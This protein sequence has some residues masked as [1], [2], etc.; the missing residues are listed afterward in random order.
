MHS[1]KNDKLEISIKNM[2]AELCKIASV[3]YQ[4]HFM[5]DANPDVW[6]GYAPNLFPIVGALKNNSYLFEG[7]TYTLPKHGFI[8]NND[9]MELHEKTNDTLTFKLIY[10]EK[11]LKMYP[12]K[13][14][15]YISFKLIDNAIQIHHT[16]KNLDINPLYFSL[17]GHPAFKCPVFKN[18]NYEDYYLE[19]EHA[20]NS[21]THLIDMSNGLISLDTKPIFNNTN[22]L[23]LKH[24]L[25]NK[26]A[27][28]FK[29][30]KSKK[31]ALKSH[32]KGRILSV[33]FQDFPYLGI[34]AKPSGD[35]VCIEPWLGIADHVDTNQDF[36]NKD[37]IIKLNPET[38][39][40]ASYLVEIDNSHLV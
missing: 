33:E 19:F 25:F 37:G 31:V 7:N 10:S 9:D 38:E 5:W 32:S 16:I 39:F 24:E 11:T 30:L 17:G 40:K 20:E 34:W 21:K 3:K 13:F 35:Y 14:E 28:V 12:F 22:T 23:P 2:G 4:T 8:R 26:D 36:K 29:D 15:F 1:L 18:E 27:L 6:R